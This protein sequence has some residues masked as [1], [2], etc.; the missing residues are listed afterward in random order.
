ARPDPKRRRAPARADDPRK[1]QGVGGRLGAAQDFPFGRAAPQLVGK[2]LSLG[3]ELKADR[4]DAI[5]FA[6]R[7]RTVRKHV[8]L[9]SAAAGADEL[10]PDH[11]VAAALDILQV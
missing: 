4:I 7:W 8:A 10:G 1:D 3:C 9:V 6:G 11:P 2:R 5:A